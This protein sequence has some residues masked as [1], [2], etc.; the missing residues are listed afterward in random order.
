MS[1]RRLDESAFARATRSMAV[2]DVSGELL[3]VGHHVVGVDEVVDH[4]QIWDG[5]R[6]V[7]WVDGV[8]PDPDLTLTRSRAVDE[9]DLLGEL[10]P[11]L[12]SAG[13]TMWVGGVA[14]DAVGT[15]GTLRKDFGGRS[16]DAGVRAVVTVPDAP[17]GPCALAITMDASVLSVTPETPAARPDGADRVDRPGGE[18]A[19]SHDPRPV[20]VTLEMFHED[21]LAWFWGDLIL[22][23][24]LW[25]QR[26]PLR[27]DIFALAAL[28]GAVRA[29]TIE[30][31]PLQAA[32]VL[33]RY[34]QV[35]EGPGWAELARSVRGA[36]A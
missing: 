31:P 33:R 18:P 25:R 23:H 14:V 11:P 29:P 10:D 13:T 36:L 26:L 30:P 9:G 27:G 1:G 34:R 3:V 17:L 2:G 6:L 28:E 8:A 20:D 35:R 7:A 16:V 4:H 19:S 22:G 12:I 15:T 5:Q 32:D 24:L 21:A